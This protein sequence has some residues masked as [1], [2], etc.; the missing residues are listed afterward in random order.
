MLRSTCT[1]AC[2]ICGATS[3]CDHADR[4]AVTKQHTTQSSMARGDRRTQQTTSIA[5]NANVPAEGRADQAERLPRRRTQASKA[6]VAQWLVRGWYLGQVTRPLVPFLP[7]CERAFNLEVS[8]PSHDMFDAMLRCMHAACRDFRLHQQQQAPKPQLQ[9]HRQ[10]TAPLHQV[11]G[12]T[13]GN[14]NGSLQDDRTLSLISRSQWHS[15]QQHCIHAS[16]C[17]S[18]VQVVLWQTLQRPI[19]VPAHVKHRKHAVSGRVTR[20]QAS[21]CALLSHPLTWMCRVPDAAS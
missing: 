13:A 18:S 8:W 19:D 4:H 16:R 15:Q 11:R 1:R 12:A 20:C 14:D 17:S 7:C 3:S 2:L 6:R 9:T 10:Y 5:E 21:A